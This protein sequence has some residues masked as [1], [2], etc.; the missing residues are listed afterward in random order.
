M[1][2]LTPAE[3]ELISGGYDPSEDIVVTA[4]SYH[5]PY[6]GYYPPS[7]YPPG[8]GYPPPYYGGG[9]GGQSGSG[10]SVEVHK[11]YKDGTSTTTVAIHA[12][13][14]G[15][16]ATASFEL[17]RDDLK[18]ITFNLS[19][20]GHSA[21]TKFDLSSQTIGQTYSLNLGNGATG[22]ISWSSGANNTR[23]VGTLTIRW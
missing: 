4:P 14:N 9:G 23:I 11:E 17:S 3:L 19:D 21:N 12:S 2:E 7:Y 13:T 18:S 22:S 20:A 15:T 6:G 1:R 16:D 8:G 10:P 5:P